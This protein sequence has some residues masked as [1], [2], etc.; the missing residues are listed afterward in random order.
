M[1]REKTS[2]LE[3]KKETGTKCTG[4]HTETHQQTGAY[5]SLKMAH[6]I[7]CDFFAILCFIK[8]TEANVSKIM[9]HSSRS[10]VHAMIP[11]RKKHNTRKMTKT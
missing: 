8:C 2:K 11:S 9:A 3:R 1:R 6:M 5:C 7:R 10:R 4:T